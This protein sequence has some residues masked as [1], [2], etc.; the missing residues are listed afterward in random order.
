MV[1]LFNMSLLFR[2]YAR[3]LVSVFLKFVFFKLSKLLPKCSMKEIKLSFLANFNIDACDPCISWII[4]IIPRT[5]KNV[6][7]YT[8]IITLLIK[9]FLLWFH[10]YKGK[11]AHH[12]LADEA[13]GGGGGRWGAAAHVA[14]VVGILERGDNF[15]ATQKPAKQ[16]QQQQYYWGD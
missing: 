13:R 11:H 5:S 2:G 1:L 12:D 8:I 14:E 6:D 10:R 4:N 15:L 7:L 9:Y 3:K 16:Q